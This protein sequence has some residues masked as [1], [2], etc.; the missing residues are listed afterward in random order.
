MISDQSPDWVPQDKEEQDIVSELRRAALCVRVSTDRQTVENQVA[1]LSKVAEAR[2]R[3][4]VAT[5]ND[6]GISGAKGRADRPGLD[7]M[8][9]QAQ[10]G[11]F[12]VVMAWAIDRLGRSLVDLIQTIEGLKACGVD[13][14]LDQQSIDTTTPAGKL[15]LQMRGAF[16]EFE[17]SMLQARIHAG[18]RRAVANGRRL[19]RPLGGDPSALDQARAAL[20]KGIGINRVAKLVGLSNGKVAKLKAELAELHA[21]NRWLD[22]QVPGR[23]A[24]NL[25]QATRRR[26]RSANERSRSLFRLSLRWP[27]GAIKGFARAGT[28]IGK[29]ESGERRRGRR[30]ERKPGVSRR[31]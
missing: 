14:Y 1:A 11:R 23:R 6:A 21:S 28:G 16:A 7:E 5:F 26:Y 20:G 27:C 17:R 31:L 15:M 12:D 24:R 13:L 2:G 22:Q 19:G 30:P 9:K 3:Q 18:L 29:R 25:P 4:I 10:R 8:L